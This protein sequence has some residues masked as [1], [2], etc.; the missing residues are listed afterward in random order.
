MVGQNTMAL[1]LVFVGGGIGSV[2]R[3]G[4]N[5]ISGA[6]IGINF[7][8]GT[9]TVNILGSLAMG[10]LAGW[11]GSR[12]EGNQLLRLFLAT[13]VLG[14]FT[15]FSAFSLDAVLL[16]Q[17]GE[18]AAAGMYAV[19]SVAAGIMGIVVGVAIVRTVIA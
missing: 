4:V 19:G 9:L 14:G 13:G 15:T 12:S 2:L 10:M 3:H 1:L 6:V 8:W 16:W 11:F 5:Q 17:K 18:M 7:P